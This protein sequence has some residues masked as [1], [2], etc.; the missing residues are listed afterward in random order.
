MRFLNVSSLDH[1]KF[2]GIRVGF[3]FEY[4]SNPHASALR[5]V[6]RADSSRSVSERS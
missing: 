5:S 3:A 2:A 4:E 1:A 6:E